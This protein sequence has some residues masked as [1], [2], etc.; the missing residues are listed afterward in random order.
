MRGKKMFLK[1]IGKDTMNPCWMKKG[2]GVGGLRVD[3]WT[4]A[5]IRREK[6]WEKEE[7]I[8]RDWE[9]WGLRRT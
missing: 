6:N 4:P 1:P 8:K 2:R 3:K 7:R 5:K 9:K